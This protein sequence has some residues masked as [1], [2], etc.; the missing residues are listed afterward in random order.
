MST[1]TVVVSL[2]AT[3]EID[4]FS[5][6][7]RLEWHN[8]P[9]GT[10][11]PMY[12]IRR[13]WLRRLAAQQLIQVTRHGKTV[14][15]AG[16][17]KDRLDLHG[18]VTAA[19]HRASY[20]WH[21]WAQVVRGTPQ[22]R[23]WTEFHQQHT[24]NPRKVS[25]AQ[26]RRRFEAQPRV[27]AMLAYAAHPGTHLELDPYEL[28]AYQA[29]QPTYTLLHWQH[30]VTGDALITDD[31]RLLRP[32]TWSLADRLRYC[33]DAGTYLSRLAGS[34]SFMALTITGQL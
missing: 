30:A 28:D 9:A 29:G 34:S 18:A 31:G 3:G 10:P 11:R 23:L 7:E 19:N 13:P 5:A 32:A 26:A 4:W 8:I 17:R 27:L 22:A 2:P 12:P 21:V 33:G 25:L 15:A 6:C 24:S 16:G 1:F 14:W 20:R